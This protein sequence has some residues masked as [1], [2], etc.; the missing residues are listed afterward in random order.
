MSPIPRSRPS[1]LVLGITFAMMCCTAH[2]VQ[3]ERE[4]KRNAGNDR[5]GNKQHYSSFQAHETSKLLSRVSN[6][7]NK[8]Y[9]LI[10]AVVF[11]QSAN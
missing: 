6:Q 1:L 5:G 10:C 2:A 8:I 9:F 4:D 11:F 3:K 7:Q